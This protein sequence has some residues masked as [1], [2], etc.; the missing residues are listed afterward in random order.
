MSFP[1]GTYP[2]GLDYNPSLGELIDLANATLRGTPTG[3]RIEYQLQNGLIL[4]LNGTGFAFDADGFPIAGML[5][6]LQLFL[7]NGTTV[8][9]SVTGLNLAMIDVYDTVDAFSYDNG[10]NAWGMN[11]WLMNGNDTVNGSSGDDDIF[12]HAGNDILKGNAGDDYVQGGAGKDTCD[13][14]AGFDQL[15]FDDTYFDPTARRGIVLDAQ[16]GTVTDPWGNNET[17]VGFEAYRGSHFADTIN[18]SAL[19]ESFI[20]MGGR[21]RIDGKGGIDEIRYDR[22]DRRG[23]MDGVTVNLTTGV[24]T[25]GFGKQDTLINIE[26]VRGTLKADSLTGS[27]VA[28]RLRGFD[29]NDFLDGRGGADDMWGGRGNDTYVVDNAGDRVNEDPGTD[30]ANGT[31]TV[32]SSI[33]FSL[34]N[35]S[36]VFGSVENLT[37]TGSGAINGTGNG[38]NNVITGNA[39]NN[40]LSGGNGNDTLNGGAGNDI[41]N[42]GAGNDKLTGGAGLDNFRFA[43]ALGTSN[44]DT[45]AD[46]VVADDTIQLE[47]AIFKALT[48]TGTLTAA[49]FRANTTGLAGDSSDRIIYETDTGKLFY[50]ADGTGA[51]AGIHFATLTTKPL[52]TN[53]DFVVI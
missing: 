43:N 53:A 19:N 1:G 16:A 27:S 12:G 38:L 7:A 40:S 36:V 41:L 28:N 42:G 6:G 32:R 21:D 35:T 29:G 2:L 11:Q 23:G 5:T 25:D 47:N 50:D 8:L 26:N 18:G 44:L 37:L 34:A 9:Q 10:F 51:A 33:T 14:G 17:F 22:D 49:A 15:S 30:S 39:G 48:A 13:G 24:A 31:D 46:F 20:G 52:V 3:T 4:R 45:I